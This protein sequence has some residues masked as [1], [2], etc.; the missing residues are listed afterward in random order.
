MSLT[1]LKQTGRII[2]S[3]VFLT[4]GLDSDT[5][6]SSSGYSVGKKKIRCQN[7]ALTS[8]LNGCYNRSFKGPAVFFSC[9][10]GP[11]GE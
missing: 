10:P 4:L 5:A 8:T 11:P 2:S 6:L 1:D 7:K 3:K 9:L